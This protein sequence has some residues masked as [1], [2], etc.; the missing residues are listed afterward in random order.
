MLKFQK[1]MKK[2]IIMKYRE[3]G[4]IFSFDMA[5]LNSI[6]YLTNTY[7]NYPY[8]IIAIGTLGVYKQKDTTMGKQVDGHMGLKSKYVSEKE[9]ARMGSFH[10]N[11]MFKF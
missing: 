5:S 2:K 1:K 4:R 6:N 8:A 11:V 9:I 10:V 3:S 7:W